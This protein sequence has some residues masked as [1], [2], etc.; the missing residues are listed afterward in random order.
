MEIWSWVLQEENCLEVFHKEIS[1]ADLEL[2]SPSRREGM[3]FE[4]ENCLRRSY[5]Q[6]LL[7]AGKRLKMYA[8]EMNSWPHVNM[9]KA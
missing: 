7:E 2:K 1:G 5:C 4:E 8:S 9:L 6:L 3:S